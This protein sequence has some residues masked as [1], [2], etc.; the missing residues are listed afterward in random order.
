MA[1]KVLM[2]PH[3]TRFKNEES[4]IKRVIEAYCKYLPQFDI[5]LV[6][7]K[8]TSYDLKAVHAGTSSDCDVAHVHGLYW[9]G[10]LHCSSWEWKANRNVIDS[11]RQSRQ[12]TVP[13]RWVAE[14]LQRDMRINPA[15]IGHG[16]A[17]DAWQ[18]RLK[19]GGY[20]LWNKN[21]NA[22]V[23]S[24]APVN[25]LAQMFPNERFLTTF[26]ADNPTPNIRET[27]T[28]PHHK[29][30]KM[31][32]QAAVYLSSTKETFGIGVL[33]AMAAGVPVLGWRHGGN[34][35]LI[36]HGVNGYLAQ[37]ENYQDLAQ[38]LAYCLKHRA[39][40][41]AN[42]RE[43]ARRWTWEAACERVA[44]VYRKAAAPEPPTVAVVIPCYNKADTIERAIDSAIAQE[45]DYVTEI[46]V[47]DDGSTDKSRRIIAEVSKRDPRI[48]PIHQE[49]R[50]VAHARN[51]GIARGSATYI[52][53]LDGDDWIQP[54]FTE[55][56][57]REL[58]RDRTLG[59]A[60]TGLRWVDGDGKSGISEWPPEF[61]YD[62]QIARKN[63]IPTCAVFRREAWVRVGG[64]RQRY[65]PTGAGSEDA[66]FW[67]AV[68]SIGYDAKKVTDKPL[69]VYSAGQGHTSEPGY[70]E[71]D[72]LAWYP[73]VY[74]GQHPFASVATPDKHAH[75][76]RQ[77]DEPV[78]SVIIPVGPGHETYLADA[79]DSLEAQSFRKWEAIVVNDSGGDSCEWDRIRAAYPY[80]HY[81][82]IN[83]EIRAG[84]GVARNMGAEAARGSFLLFLDADDFIN[85]S[86]P[87]ALQAMVDAWA[88]E[89][90]A[91]YSDY[92][93]RAFIDDLSQLAPDLQRNVLHQDPDGETYIRYE[94]ADF[95]CA[96]AIRQP[97]SDQP[98]RFYIWNLI[99]TLVPASWHHEIG[100]FDEEMESWEDWDYWIRLA[101]AGKCF[102]RIPEPYLIYK[103]YSGGRR[104]WAHKEGSKGR[105][106]W[107][108]LIESLKV[109]RERSGVPDMGCNCKG[110]T[111]TPQI[112]VSRV[113]SMNAEKSQ[114]QDDDFTLVKYMHPNRGK[115]LVYGQATRT[116]YGYRAGGGAEQFLVHKD[117]LAATPHLFQQVS[118][119]PKSAPE[120][121]ETAPPAAIAGAQVEPEQ[122]PT[123]TETAPK[124]KKGFDVQTL[125]GIGPSIAAQLEDD[126]LASLEGIL[127]LGPEGL[128]SYRGMNLEKAQRVIEAIEAFKAV[129]A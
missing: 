91:V 45:G 116:P 18:H 15:V 78:I 111:P 114:F 31:V 7:K 76:V 92:I 66:A 65:A 10:D 88:E 122:K 57:V 23:C 32:Q 35:D 34:V 40:L 48:I 117:D 2:E 102:T 93:G 63:Q 103:Y 6:G 113:S 96:R 90:A 72:W 59:V 5:E 64:Y 129:Q 56:C 110:K 94:A 84:A 51:T 29:M 42:G 106:N 22:D 33:E 61:D 86:H 38:G 60:Y 100:G 14:T 13:S 47:V 97:D 54:G 120:S 11:I 124:P 87:E 37:P 70:S 1:I 27:G 62:D 30:K 108:G 50:G 82:Q 104:E 36:R 123:V 20:I 127:S 41:G 12:V 125:P 75:P 119:L 9:T 98:G 39:T 69:F 28:V 118:T 68:G 112:T 99:S 58:E 105:Q 121:Q 89:E 67:T 107:L 24:P 3:L 81:I 74:D 43:M 77:Y 73:W 8:S 80:I 95:D 44:E 52:C 25:R 83:T 115:H 128:S 55:A 126:N 53:C 19:N 16:I 46:I 17:W 85:P 21:R 26:A 71:V 49:N 79:L 4:G 101:R 109:K